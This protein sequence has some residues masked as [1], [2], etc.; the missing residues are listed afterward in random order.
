MEQ[1][2]K[3]GAPFGN[4]NAKG[5]GAP[6]GNKNAVGNRGGGAPLKNSNAVKTGE[7]KS[8]WYETLTEEEKELLDQIEIADPIEQIMDEIKLYSY[9]EAF[10]LQRI[11]QLKS[12]MTSKQR[13]VLREL[14][15]V[16]DKVKVGNRIIEKDDYKMMETKVEEIESDP[17][18]Q[19]LAYEE[20]LTRIQ[21]KKVKAISTLHKMV[22]NNQPEV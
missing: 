18:K 6:L 17:V 21:D 3:R 20:A 2:K 19:L 11:N 12:G 15:K 14:K 5:H 7:Y 8:L 10:I 9:R 16:K 22:S 4:Q 13:R 1:A